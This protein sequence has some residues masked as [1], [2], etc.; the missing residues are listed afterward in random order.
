MVRPVPE[1]TVVPDYL[2]CPYGH[3]HEP[4]TDKPSHLA[5]HPGMVQHRN[6]LLA[7]TA[8]NVQDTLDGFAL[9]VSQPKPVPPAWAPAND[10]APWNSVTTSVILPLAAGSL[11]ISAQPSR[12]GVRQGPTP[13]NAPEVFK[14]PAGPFN[15][16]IQLG[17][18]IALRVGKGAVA[19][20]IFAA[21][22]SPSGA[23]TGTGGGGAAAAA[24]YIAGDDRGMPLGAIRLV[25]YHFRGRYMPAHVD[26]HGAYGVP[27]EDTHLRFGALIK[28][29]AVPD[30]ADETR[31]VEALLASL[32]AAEISAAETVSDGSKLWGV[33]A[34][35]DPS[36]P[37]PTRGTGAPGSTLSL[38]VTR[39]LTCSSGLADNHN[40]SIHTRWNCLVSREVNGE[41]VVPGLLTINGELAPAIPPH[42]P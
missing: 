21:D 31:V 9:N 12:A 26:A 23:G 6:V 39:N 18:T 42:L 24:L 32:A 20:R 33:T 11:W 25:A 16:T 2:D 22:A 28:A 17:T 37:I 8:I 38:S 13:A 3:I 4:N 29:A 36:E 14:I 40:Q 27:D 5:Y 34:R 41:A 15:K 35:L 19:M 1:I 7:T 30:G 10:G